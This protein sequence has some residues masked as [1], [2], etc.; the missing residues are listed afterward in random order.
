MTY[1]SKTQPSP[2]PTSHPAPWVPW[3]MTPARMS[4]EPVAIPASF[5]P[6]LRRWACPRKAS[7]RS[8]RAL[9]VGAESGSG[10]ARV[11]PCGAVRPARWAMCCLTSRL[12]S[13]CPW[14][15][16][17]LP[18]RS[19]ALHWKA[20][21]PRHQPVAALTACPR[22]LPQVSSPGHLS[23]ATTST[24]QQYGSRGPL[25]RVPQRWAQPMPRPFTCLQDIQT[26]PD[27]SGPLIP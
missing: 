5:D 25:N 15:G 7:V 6:L 24:G 22:P 23:W 12:E 26:H 10:R 3:L 2:A 16:H 4:L 19:P 8:L 14:K 9:H 18:G 13:R 27:D 1:S 17:A 20:Q 21:Q 11:D